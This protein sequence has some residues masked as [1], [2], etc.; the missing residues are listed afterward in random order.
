MLFGKEHVERYQATDGAEGHDWNG[1]T[2]LLLTTTGRRSGKRYTTPLIYQRHGDDYLIVASHGG[3]DIP[4]DW[5]LNLQSHPE[6]EVQVLA[7]KFP[8]RARTA[9][10]EEKPEMWRTMTATWPDY[11][12]YQK[13][14]DRE[15]PIVVLERAS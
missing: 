10:R 15:I 11:D 1:T 3:S 7:D 5:Y 9:D 12:E 6:V 4:P 13:K 8:A 14:T 2:A